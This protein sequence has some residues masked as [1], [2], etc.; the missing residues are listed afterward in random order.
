M[1]KIEINP[2]VALNVEALQSVFKELP[3]AKPLVLTL[4][5]GLSYYNNPIVVAQKDHKSINLNHVLYKLEDFGVLTILSEV[6]D[7]YSVVLNPR[8][9]TIRET[10]HSIIEQSELI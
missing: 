2:N 8:I 6:G 5:D 10:K 1:K 4:I 7:V 3:E 9:A